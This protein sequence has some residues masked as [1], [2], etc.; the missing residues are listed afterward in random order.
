M[1]NPI[2]SDIIGQ[3]G[4]FFKATDQFFNKIAAYS[5]RSLEGTEKIKPGFG[6]RMGSLLYYRKYPEFVHE[7]LL[8]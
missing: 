4:E 5:D 2:L 6:N 3:Y 1:S 8:E 7:M